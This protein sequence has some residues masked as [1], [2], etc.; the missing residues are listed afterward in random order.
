MNNAEFWKPLSGYESIYLISS[1][2]RIKRV[3]SGMGAKK[4]LILKPRPTKD[5]YVK[6]ALY[7]GVGGKQTFL[8][9]RLVVINFIRP[10][11]GSEEVDHINGIKDDNRLQ[12]LEPVSKLVNM[13][14]SFAKGRYSAR[15]SKQGLSK[16]TEQMVV[17]IRNAHSRGVL[18][19]VEIAEIYEV[20]KTTIGR[21]VNGSVWK[22]VTKCVLPN[23]N[24]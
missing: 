21:V 19:N 20:S 3:K 14:R 24:P 13:R 2:G 7:D 16:L 4:G 5:G 10:L 11:V 18:L 1:H 9:H 6:Y 17:D 23:P 22:H 15:G 8:A 12:N